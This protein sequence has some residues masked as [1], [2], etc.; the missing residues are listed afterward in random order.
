VVGANLGPRALA[1]D[2]AAQLA[3]F[4]ARAWRERDRARLRALIRA[5]RAG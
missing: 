1:L 2:D 4:G 3:E 5:R